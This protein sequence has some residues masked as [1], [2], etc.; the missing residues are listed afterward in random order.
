MEKGARVCG[1]KNCTY[2][3]VH[4]ISYDNDVMHYEGE[5]KKENRFSTLYS[6]CLSAGGIELEKE[7]NF[8]KNYK[9]GRKHIGDWCFQLKLNQHIIDI[10]T[11]R[12]LTIL[13]IMNQE[14]EEG[15]E[16]DESQGGQ[17][18]KERHKNILSIKNMAAYSIYSACF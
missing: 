2:I 5:D 11:A 14:K 12:F 15:D 3:D 6:S 13:R 7:A 17:Q 4:P 8:D 18:R 1:V 10:A 16:D 9:K